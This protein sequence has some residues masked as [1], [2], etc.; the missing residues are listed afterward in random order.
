MKDARKGKLDAKSDEGIFLRYSTKIKIYKCLNSNTNKV[1]ESEN[2]RVDQFVEKNEVECK[3]ELG[4]YMNF[5]YINSRI[6]STL[7]KA[8][9]KFFKQQQLV[10]VEV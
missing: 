5:V 8:K 2:V 7:S 3:N 4:D 10:N 1:V 9:K 6:L